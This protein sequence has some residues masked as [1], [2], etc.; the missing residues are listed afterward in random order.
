MRTFLTSCLLTLTALLFTPSAEATP[1]VRNST[2]ETT[3]VEHT[4]A[5][6]PYAVDAV[7]MKQQQ[8]AAKKAAKH[9]KRIERMKKR[10]AKWQSRAVD[11]DAKTA[12]IVAYI[13]IFG[14][15]ISLLALHEEGSNH[16]I[17]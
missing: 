7:N 9:Q 11:D 10:L 6:T 5:T 16:R 4:V 1:L 12:A 2:A 3:N 17:T 14:F 8:K 13:T 15:L